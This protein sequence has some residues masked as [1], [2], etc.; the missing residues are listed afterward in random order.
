MISKRKQSRVSPALA[1]LV[2]LGALLLILGFFFGAAL[3]G[4]VAFL[5]IPFY[6]VERSAVSW[7][8]GFLG[9]FASREN[10]AN[11]NEQLRRELAQG[12]ILVLDRNRLYEE[13]LALKERL[14]RLAEPDVIT[15]GVVLAPPKVPYDT[16]LLDAGQSDN[17]EV[18]DKVAAGGTVLIGEITEVYAQSSRATLYSA[19]GVSHEGFLAKEGLPITLEGQGSGALRGTIPK[20]VV[21]ER[22]DEVSF[23]SILGGV[24][25]F[26]EHFEAR[27]GESFQ[28]LYIRLPV[29]PL[30]LR[31]VDIWRRR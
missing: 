8:A 7:T 17:V 15:A 16:L 12:E 11:E 13:N 25:G 18:G 28:T 27:E 31:Y 10:L 1:G 3:R 23:P 21:V 5:L 24:M 19:P 20:S 26:V 6:T 9:G 14:G 29:N 4:A 22:G 2:G 30:A